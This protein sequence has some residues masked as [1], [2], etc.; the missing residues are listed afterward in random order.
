MAKKSGTKTK[1]KVESATGEVQ[2]PAS[3]LK[4]SDVIR[5]TIREAKQNISE[6]YLT[7]AESLYEAYHREYY[8]EEWGYSSWEEYCSKDLD[9][10]YR[11]TM[12][13]IEIWDKAKGLKIPKE[14]MQKLGWTKM[15]DLVAV[16]NEE[17]AK[18]WLKKAE[19]MSSR[20]LT[21]AVKL[22]RKTDTSDVDLPTITSMTLRMSESE[23]SAILDA[24]DVAKR[25]CETDNAVVAL[26]MIC[27]DWMETQAGQP[28]RRTLENHIA[29]LQKIYGIE[30]SWK[31]AEKVKEG[32]K[33][34]A[35]KKNPEPEVA[36]EVEDSAVDEEADLE[37][38]EDGDDGSDDG[39]GDV[40][41]N[42]LLDIEE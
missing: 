27:Q 31:V 6:N 37:H 11:K 14:K 9:E 13:L 12:Y 32:G 38:D 18:E 41:I 5:D 2:V 21:E 35:T 10:S 24:I 15:K 36:A 42:K 30:M 26:E 7:L 28:E 4:R 3:K 8:K 22:V 16:L 40:D 17:N 20:E 34:K 25:L 1:S 19:T 29:Y 33:K 39:D 23:A